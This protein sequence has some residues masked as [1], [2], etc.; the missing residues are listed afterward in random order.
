M[1][2][3]SIHLHLIHLITYLYP[4]WSIFITKNCKREIWNFMLDEWII[5]ISSYK[6]FNIWYR[7]LRV[8]ND[9]QKTLN[10][11]K[12]LKNKAYQ[13]LDSVANKLWKTLLNATLWLN[14]KAWAVGVLQ[15]QSGIEALSA[16]D[17]W[18]TMFW[19]C[20][21]RRIFLCLNVTWR[22]LA[23]KYSINYISMIRYCGPLSILGSVACAW[24]IQP[25]IKSCLG[26]YETGSWR[27]SLAD[28]NRRFQYAL[29]HA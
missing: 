3:M 21:R 7:I 22:I 11:R 29:Q 12:Y 28:R 23:D 27:T 15:V 24:R 4:N 5:K 1:Q 19:S 10:L 14:I 9:L 16:K 2:F 13:I 26:V 17:L 18:R 6:P 25:K 8:C 20:L